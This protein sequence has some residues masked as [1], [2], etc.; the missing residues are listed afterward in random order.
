[1]NIFN[2]NKR[3]LSLSTILCLFLCIQ[4]AKAEWFKANRAIMG[5][6]IHVELWHTN[7]ILAEKH[8]QS[9]I[10]EMHRIDELMS[11]YKVNSE[12][13]L[14]NNQAEKHPV[15]ISSELFNLIQQSI[16]PILI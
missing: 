13:S 12:L 14:I 1:M 11:P 2:K 7:K 4:T 3:L 16:F 9:V 6:A 15:K 10:D 8:I 5:T